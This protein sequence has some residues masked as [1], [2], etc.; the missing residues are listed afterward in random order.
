MAGSKKRRQRQP[1]LRR[2]GG[3]VDGGSWAR[4]KESGPA[5]ERKREVERGESRGK[6]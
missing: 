3:G 2:G 4:K 5:I 1:D 6:G